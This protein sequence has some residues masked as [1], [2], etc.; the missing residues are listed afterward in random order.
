MKKMKKLFAIL[1][2]MAM[3]M[4][5]GITGFAAESCT[6][7]INNAGPEAKYATLQ[8]IK[9]SETTKTGWDFMT[10]NIAEAYTDAFGITQ[11][12]VSGVP[13]PEQK[14]EAIKM[15]IE[16]QKGSSAEAATDSQITTALKTIFNANKTTL[17]E[18]LKEEEPSVSAAGVYYVYVTEKGYVYNPMA[19][20]VGFNY[21]NGA[22]DGVPEQV[23]LDAKRR[24]TTGTKTTTDA[25]KIVAIGDTV[26]YEVEP[27]AIPRIPDDEL[28]TATYTFMDAIKGADYVVE[29]ESSEYP[30]K[31]KLTVIIND[32]TDNPQ[33]FYADVTNVSN[34]DVLNGTNLMDAGYTS[35]ITAELNSLLTDNTY[36]DQTITIS[37]QVK[38]NDVSIKNIGGINGY[39]SD[40]EE[41]FT[42]QIT[43]L[44]YG[45]NNENNVLAGA[46]FEVR[47]D[48]ATGDALKFTENKD[49]SY[50][51]APNAIGTVGEDYF[52]EVTTG[53]NGQVVLKGLG[54]GQY[55]F[56]E[57][58]A[59]KGYHIGGALNNGADLIVPVTQTENNGVANG[60]LLVNGK[61]NNT[62]LSALPSTGGMGTTL[63]TIAGCVI[64]ISAAGLFFATR[65]K[66][67]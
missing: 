46:G 51:Y 1:M 42:A 6:I 48:A 22:E 8:L 5:L 25:D 11:S 15:L 21:D 58:T 60:I 53:T 3:V 38:A 63:F 64:M 55:Y 31:V 29:P 27:T 59:P 40:T 66:A 23:E 13:T 37:Y 45:D 19:A 44:K 50:T 17:E 65:K 52:T 12:D 18:S 57:V 10:D 9:A 34:T 32:N 35:K 7:N 67:N 30:G 4:G 14:Q 39:F 41:V 54:T 16:K 56:K 61:L 62:K 33:Y 49:G 47:K 36:A 28:G 43:V 20:Y 26:T 2:T 24:P